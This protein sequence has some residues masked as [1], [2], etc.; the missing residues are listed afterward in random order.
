MN[1]AI[2]ASS[3]GLPWRPALVRAACTVWLPTL[4]PLV[5]G[6]LSGCGHCATNYWLSLPTVPGLLVPALLQLQGAPF[7]VVGGLVALLLFALTALLLRELPAKL[8]YA[9]Q[10]IVALAVAFESVGIAAAMRA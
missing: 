1:P 5:A 7:F 8:G 3:L 10:A 6:M 9:A 4:A 2:A